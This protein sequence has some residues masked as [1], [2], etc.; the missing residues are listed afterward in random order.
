MSNDKEDD[1]GVYKNVNVVWNGNICV[2]MS[3][4]GNESVCK[5]DM[6]LCVCPVIGKI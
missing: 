6:W 1:L 5:Y 2:Y 4:C 3:M